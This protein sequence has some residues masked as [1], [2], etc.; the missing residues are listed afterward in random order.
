[1]SVAQAADGSSI[2][3]KQDAVEQIVNGGVLAD[4]VL[5]EAEGEGRQRRYFLDGD[6]VAKSEVVEAVLEADEVEQPGD[7]PEHG[8]IQCRYCGDVLG[9]L[10]GSHMESH[11]DE[12]PQS[13]D[14][15]RAFVAAEEDVEPEEVPIAP[16]ELDSLFEEAGQHDEETRQELSELNQERWEQGEYD[17]LR[18]D[19]EE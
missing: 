15:Y 16:D 8:S 17:H 5:A 1:M 18:G 12:G 2:E 19:D 9:Y 14:E 10:T 7:E 4:G 3:S 11:D 13:V 6:N